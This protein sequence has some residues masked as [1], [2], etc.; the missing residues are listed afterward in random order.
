MPRGR[1]DR[2]VNFAKAVEKAI[3]RGD[4]N[5]VGILTYILSQSGYIDYM[6]DFMP[7]KVYQSSLNLLDH[8]HS[9]S[10]KSESA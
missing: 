7:E 1:T 5:V 8:D 10:E 9:K 4:V 2:A 6:I 3:E